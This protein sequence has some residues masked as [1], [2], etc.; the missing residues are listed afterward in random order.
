MRCSKCGYVSFDHLNNCPKCSKDLSTV[1]E[2]LNLLDFRPE[3]PFL[4]GSLVGEMEGGGGQQELS[5][6]QETELELGGL[7]MGEPSASEG[8]D[9][10]DLEIPSEDNSS[11][12]VSLS[13]IALDDL[14]TIEASSMGDAEGGELQLDDLAELSS[15]DSSAAEEDEGFLGLEIEADGDSFGDLGGFEDEISLE[16]EAS[17]ESATADP[18]AELELDLNDDDLSALAKELEG[19]LDSEGGEEKD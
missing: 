1:R 8:I 18:G 11:D 5:L 10:G 3:V 12:E 7:G 13:E 16:P 9:M 14:E 15:G 6:T 2:D 19:H 17:A 4:L